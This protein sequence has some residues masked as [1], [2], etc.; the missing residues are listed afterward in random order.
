MKSF[1]YRPY[2]ARVGSVKDSPRLR[3]IELN[4][5]AAVIFSAEDLSAGMV[6]EPIDGIAGYS[7][8]T[9]TELAVRIVVYSASGAPAISP[10]TKP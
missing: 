6:G 3:A 2:A 4:G 8:A 1:T 10:A 7:P 9:A 5:R